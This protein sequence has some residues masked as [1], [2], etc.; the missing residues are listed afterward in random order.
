[1]SEPSRRRRAGPPRRTAGGKTCPGSSTLRFSDPARPCRTVGTYASRAH[2]APA[3]DGAGFFGRTGSSY[4][5]ARNTYANVP[6]GRR[7]DTR[8]ELARRLEKSADRLDSRRDFDNGARYRERFG[9]H[10][11]GFN[12]DRAAIG[13]VV[14]FHGICKDIPGL[15]VDLKTYLETGE[16]DPVLGFAETEEVPPLTLS[17]AETKL[18]ESAIPAR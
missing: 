5:A 12:P 18:R 14:T 16:R 9:P 15:S 11:Q 7:E 13:R 6:G 4:T 17:G 1:M 10:F 3:I 8:A 2:A